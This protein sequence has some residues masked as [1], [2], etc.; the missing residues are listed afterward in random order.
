MNNIMS[1]DNERIGRIKE[2]LK[3][4]KIDTLIC[5]LPENI[6]FLTGFWPLTGTSWVVFTAEGQSKLIVPACE[7]LEAEK[8]GQKDFLTYEW[9]HLKAGDP[10]TQIANL[11]KKIC[12]ELKNKNSV[13]GIEENF[14]G[15]APPLNTG[16]P[17]VPCKSSKELIVNTLPKANIVD[18]TKIINE[19][20]I[21]KT[22][23]EIEK[24]RIANEIAGFGLAAFKEY[25]KEGI[26]EI[27]LACKVNSA[28]AINGCGYKDTISAR[29]FAQISSGQGTERAW[30]PCVITSG[31]KLKNGDIVILE[32]GAV[33]DGFW[34]DNT[35]V[36]VIG[37]ASDK[38]KE[39]YNMLLEAQLAAI[40]KIK[41]DVK[42]GD[43]DKA[44]RDVINDAGYGEYFIHI[45]GHGVGWRYHEFPPLL[46]PE[47]DTLLE[48]GMITS[49]EP[50]VYIPGF[51]GMR[52]EDNVAIGKNGAD[53]LT[54]F[55]K[56]L[57]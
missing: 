52:I 39:I 21:T 23:D 56:R 40:E 57:D 17:S 48:E 9:A 2:L 42:M 37:G 45:T 30:R 18:A 24:F 46:A 15:V 27:E 11:L 41:P 16:E 4:N 3:G 14:A 38:Q 54:T 35:R 50:G 33:A 25:A 55:S 7:A 47:N 43:V 5:Q 20:R 51:G 26:S 32:L 29:G 36:V 28:I 13:I 34:A 53:I 44:A 6:V 8:Y 10:S 19:L 1:I 12:H 22:K 49:V 31:R